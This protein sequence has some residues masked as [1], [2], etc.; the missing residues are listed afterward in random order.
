MKAAWL[1]MLLGACS[2]EVG[3]LEVRLTTAPGSTILDSVQTLRMTLTN[4]LT[5]ETAERTSKGFSIS[6]D[7]PANGDVTALRVEGL[8]ASGNL[9]ANGATPTFPI[10]ALN[11]RIVI[12]M[13]APLSVGAAPTS[14][15]AGRSELAVAALPYGAIFAGGRLEGGALS[16]AVSVYN[17]FDHTQVTGLPLPAPRAAL[18]MAVGA[19]NVAYMFGGTDEAG[20]P[21]ASVW[22]FDTTVAPAGQFFDFGTKDEFARSGAQL[23]PIGNEHYLVTGM[24]TAELAALNGTMTARSEMPALP[25][26]VGLTGNDGKLAAIFAGP[27]DVVQFKNGMFTS[28]AIPEAA[29]AG[30]SVVAMPGGKVL[31]VCGST[32]AVRIDAASGAAEVFPGIPSAAKT[33]CAA[34]ATS[35]HLVVAGGDA[36]GADA[37]VELYDAE[38]LALVATTQLVVP[39]KDATAIA[40]SNDQIM[41]AGGVDAAGVPVG[42]LELFTPPLE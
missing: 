30:A 8:D 33:G 31:V 1:A 41:I 28:L 39:R 20:A 34:A 24:P 26:G 23:V 15:T 40:L 18:A 4:P 29:R 9:V 13:A 5:V 42:T 3:T 2:G 7:L 19:G 32:D 17:V 6:I 25:A 27:D 14:L 12:Y 36:A 10:G 37:T 16:D 38:S 11:G 21:A 22:R 35:R